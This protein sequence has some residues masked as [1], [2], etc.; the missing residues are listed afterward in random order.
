MTTPGIVLLVYS[1]IVF[2]FYV[3]ALTGGADLGTGA[4]S[5]FPPRQRSDSYRRLIREA[6]TPVWEAHH[7]W[8]VIV[9]VLLFVTMPTAFSAMSVALF[10]PL[11]LTLIFLVLRGA[12][13]AFSAYADGDVCSSAIWTLTFGVSSLAAPFMLGVSVGSILSGTIR[14]DPASGWVASNFVSSW[15]ATFPIVAGLFMTASVLHLSAIYLTLET[16]DPSLQEDFRQRAGITGS[17]TAGLLLLSLWTA[18]SGARLLFEHAV[19]GTFFWVFVFLIGLSLVGDMAGLYLKKYGWSRLMAWTFV[20]ILM[21]AGAAA[22][23]PYILAP[24]LS[25]SVAAAP[26]SVLWPITIAVLLGTVFI[27]VPS[28]GALYFIFKRHAFRRTTKTN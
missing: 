12:A 2:C 23:Y 1:L 9:V 17:L 14:V 28:F 20:T 16:T 21:G 4:W 13:F 26:A 6:L 11:L 24:D 19:K 27:V 8:L 18:S 22:Q 5:L 15:A 10:I 3:Y 7:V 25:L